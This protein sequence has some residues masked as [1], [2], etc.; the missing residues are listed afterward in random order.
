MTRQLLASIIVCCW[1]TLPALADEN[2]DIDLIPPDVQ[3]G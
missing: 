2:Q 1:L 3:A